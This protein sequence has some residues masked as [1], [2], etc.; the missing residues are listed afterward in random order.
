MAPVPLAHSPVSRTPLLPRAHAAAGDPFGSLSAPLVGCEAL[1]PGQASALLNISPQTVPG[2]VSVFWRVPS[3]ASHDRPAPPQPGPA[4]PRP[5]LRSSPPSIFAECLA[6]PGLQMQA[7]RGGLRFSLPA[8]RPLGSSGLKQEC[9]APGAPLPGRPQSGFHVFSG[10]AQERGG[11][12]RGRSHRGALF[13][14]S[15][16]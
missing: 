16:V 4:P 3:K 9:E 2:S 13:P 8:R 12:S 15:S 7:E 6:F 11:P 10:R 5:G 1:E 14:A